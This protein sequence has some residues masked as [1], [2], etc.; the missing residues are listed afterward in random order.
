[1]TPK[2]LQVLLQRLCFLNLECVFNTIPFPFK[3]YSAAVFQFLPLKWKWS[4]KKVLWSARRLQVF[5]WTKT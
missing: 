1:M 4:F 5:V 3:V 2:N